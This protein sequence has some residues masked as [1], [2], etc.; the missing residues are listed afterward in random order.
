MDFYIFFFV[1]TSLLQNILNCKAHNFLSLLEWGE[2]D[3]P[4]NSSMN[5]FS[6]CLMHSLCEL[7]A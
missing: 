3:F 2:G 4:A 7:Q 1:V 6:T 5:D